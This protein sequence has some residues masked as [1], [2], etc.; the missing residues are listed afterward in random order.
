MKM[1]KS[2]LKKLSGQV[3][4]SKVWC[5]CFIA[6]FLATAGNFGAVNA[7]V[8][9]RIVAVVNGDIIVLT[10]LN[11]DSAPIVKKIK[12][13]KLSPD[14]EKE[15]LAGYREYALNQ[16]INQKLIDQEIKRYG[17]SVSEGDIDN[18]IAQLRESELL[19]EEQFVQTLKSSLGLSMV[20]YKK[21]VKEQLLRMK[22][23][24]SKVKSKVVVTDEDRKLFYE[25]F[26]KEYAGGK[27][28]YLKNIIMKVPAD[29]SESEKQ[30]IFKKMKG[31]LAKLK[32]GASF[33]TMADKHSESSAPG[34]G[35]DLGFFRFDDLSS[36]LQEALSGVNEGE[37]TPILDTEMGFQIL[38]VKKIEEDLGKT[39]K[40][41]SPDIDR[42]IYNASVNMKYQ[43]WLIELRKRSHIKILE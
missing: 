30:N 17:I 28:Y 15:E 16:L 37:T 29:A 25:K 19:S 24:D 43:S 2:I 26:E 11:R 10:E 40:E 5:C 18:Y 4:F 9:D 34:E 12:A 31:V 23:I 42:K 6:F 41:A 32:Q 8:V 3:V 38:Y 33:E 22:L 27:R 14:R 39:L 35:G 7:E 1:K 20:E 21:K 36:D 13:E